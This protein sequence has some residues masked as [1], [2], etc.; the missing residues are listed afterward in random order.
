MRLPALALGLL[1]ALSSFGCSTAAL[2]V[3]QFDDEEDEQPV[4]ASRPLPVA[5]AALPPLGFEAGLPSGPRDASP[6]PPADWDAGRPIPPS[7]FDSG[8]P[9]PGDTSASCKVHNPPGCPVSQAQGCNTGQPEHCLYPQPA[10]RLFVHRTCTGSGAAPAILTRVQ[11]PHD[12]ARE[13]P[14]SFE[15]LDTSDCARRPVSACES[16]PSDQLAV[17]L[18]LETAALGCGLKTHHLALIFDTQGCAR[19][20]FGREIRDPAIRC[21]GKQLNSVRFSCAPACAI[22][23]SDP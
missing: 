9:W 18:A 19:A 8:I 7:L 1:F 22:A 21:I 10:P 15:T 5:D 2:P 20:I 17:D 4:D 14:S 13:I 11:C 12:C 16:F 3:S 23:N 6:P